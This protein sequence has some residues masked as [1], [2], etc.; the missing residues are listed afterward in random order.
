MHLIPG[1]R[2]ISDRY[3]KG[4]VTSESSVPG[5]VDVYFSANSYDCIYN[6]HTGKRYLTIGH[7]TIRLEDLSNDGQ[8][9]Q[10]T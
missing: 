3:G 1:D 5:C 8:S 2:I 6:A 9:T 7:D 4:H 10:S